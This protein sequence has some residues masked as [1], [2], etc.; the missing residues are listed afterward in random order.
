MN[1]GAHDDPA[2][3]GE[4]PGHG[5]TV[6]L[7]HLEGDET[8]LPH[9]VEHRLRTGQKVDR[10]GDDEIDLY[11][12][13]FRDGAMTRVP[14]P[15]DTRPTVVALTVCVMALLMVVCLLAA[16]RVGGAIA[17]DWAWV[18]APLWVPVSVATVALT[19]ACVWLAAA[20]EREAAR[21][22]RV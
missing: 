22:R 20:D 4:V 3:Y 21:R 13:G 1:H 2:D 8:G 5:P 9:A 16:L 15:D 11:A 12:D 6:I 17:W 14:P 18:L 10:D 7:A 19:L